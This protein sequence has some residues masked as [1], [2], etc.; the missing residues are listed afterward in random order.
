MIW[1]ANE[2]D[3][4]GFPAMFEKCSLA[5]ND[6][7]IGGVKR[8]SLQLSMFARIFPGACSSNHQLRLGHGQSLNH[9]PRGFLS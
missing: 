7:L 9:W 5:A 1:F 3:V 2:Q 6:V 4:K 8:S